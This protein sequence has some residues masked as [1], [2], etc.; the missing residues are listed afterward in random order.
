MLNKAFRPDLAHINPVRNKFKGTELNLTK[1]YQLI[2]IK[3][4]L[5]E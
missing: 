5:S 4:F 3:R 1:I 2:S